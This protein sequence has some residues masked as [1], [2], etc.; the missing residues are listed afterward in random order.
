MNKCEV[1]KTTDT[2]NITKGIDLMVSTLGK[3]RHSVPICSTY[4]WKLG[5]S[6]SETCFIVD[7]LE[8]AQIA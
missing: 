1:V 6:W 8:L 3:K 4:L 5:G 2:K 7:G